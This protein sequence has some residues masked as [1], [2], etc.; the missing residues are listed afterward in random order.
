MPTEVR[1]QNQTFPVPDEL[2]VLNPK[3]VAEKGEEA[4]RRERDIA[5]K[6]W[7]S[8]VSPAATNANLSWS[9]RDG[10]DGSK[11]TVVTVT[12]QLGTKGGSGPLSGAVASLVAA[13]QTIPALYL[14][15]WELKLLQLEGRLDF[16]RLLAY[17]PRIQ[18]VLSGS[19]GDGRAVS[20]FAHRL[21][22]A[23]GR[24]CP[25]VPLGF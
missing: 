15:A 22:V 4:A 9:E 20:D 3:L 1:L 19:D 10:P 8:Q 17:Q 21:R 25:V 23:P 5:L 24:P 18:E 14:L 16:P 11:V 2:V 7:L 13:P 12:P 6:R